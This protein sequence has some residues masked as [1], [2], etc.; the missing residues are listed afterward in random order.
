MRVRSA[1]RSG[2]KER[3]HTA[4]IPLWHGLGTGRGVQVGGVVPRTMKRGYYKIDRV[5]CSMS[6]DV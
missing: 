4:G 6:L 2:G 3:L 1:Q 5:K